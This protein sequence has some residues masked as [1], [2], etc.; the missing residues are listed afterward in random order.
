MQHVTVTTE[1][2][3]VTTFRPFTKKITFKLQ[4]VPRSLMVACL[5]RESGVVPERRLPS[6]T[7]SLRPPRGPPGPPLEPGSARLCAG[8]YA[9]ASFNVA[10]LPRCDVPFGVFSSCR[11]TWVARSERWF[12]SFRRWCDGRAEQRR[13]KDPMSPWR[14]RH[15]QQ[16]NGRFFCS[17]D[18]VSA[19]HILWFKGVRWF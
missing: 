10:A 17:H 12:D 13:E 16:N 15:E 19:F 8:S 11:Q 9:I 6:R 18:K 14:P 1:I 5:R 4:T 2:Q 7:K 3:T